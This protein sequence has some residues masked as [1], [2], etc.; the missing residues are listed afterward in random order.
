MMKQKRILAIFLMG[1]A[2]LMDAAVTAGASAET[3]R[4]LT[5]SGLAPEVL[6]KKFKQETGIDVQV[7]LSN[8]EDIISRLRATGGAGFDLAQPSHDR[9]TGPQ[10]DFHIYK[11]MDLSKVKLQQFIPGLLEATKAS[12]TIITSMKRISNQLTWLTLLW[13]AVGVRSVAVTRS[14][15]A[16][17]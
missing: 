5:W 8:N 11:P 4:L 17:K 12:T 16:P 2:G 13:N 9:I 14:T 3:L 15:R 6:V 1:L 10:A 7:T